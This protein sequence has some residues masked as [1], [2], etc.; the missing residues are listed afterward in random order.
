MLDYTGISSY[1]VGENSDKR[2]INGAGTDSA[3]AFASRVG[4]G[5]APLTNNS[6]FQLYQTPQQDYSTFQFREPLAPPR[7]EVPTAPQQQITLLGLLPANLAQ[8]V[9]ANLEKIA[10]QLASFFY[11]NR[12]EKQLEEEKLNRALNDA[13]G[14]GFLGEV[15]KVEETHKGQMADGETNG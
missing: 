1:P 6:P 8:L 14:A 10:G 2:K 3:N 15:R 7:L 9:S 12:R 4:G 11:G 5:S 13:F